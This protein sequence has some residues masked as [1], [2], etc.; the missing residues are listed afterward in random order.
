MRASGGLHQ[1]SEDFRG[2]LRDDRVA[3]TA[4]CNHSTGYPINQQGCAGVGDPAGLAVVALDPV[5]AGPEG[6]VALICRGNWSI[7]LRPSGPV[8]DIPGVSFQSFALGA[9]HGDIEAS[10]IA[11]GSP[12]WAFDPSGRRPVA[13]VP[14]GFDRP[15]SKSAAAGAGHGAAAIIITSPR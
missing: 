6:S 7:R 8:I 2:F 12:T 14:G 15:P 5:G 4:P 11:A 3:E 10:F 1:C 13:D 9:F